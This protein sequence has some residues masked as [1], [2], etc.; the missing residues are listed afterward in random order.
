[1]SLIQE[2]SHH[3]ESSSGMIVLHLQAKS[4]VE[5]QPNHLTFLDEQRLD[6]RPSRTVMTTSY[7]AKERSVGNA[8]RACGSHVLR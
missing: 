3:E 5:R 4:E 6:V 7:T 8:S 2:V 1:M